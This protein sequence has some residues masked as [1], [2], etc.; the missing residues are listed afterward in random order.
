[1]S[2]YER[3][4]TEALR[5]SVQKKCPVGFRKNRKTGRCERLRVRVKLRTR[6]S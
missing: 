2:L 6:R 5:I 3:V 4:V 1:V